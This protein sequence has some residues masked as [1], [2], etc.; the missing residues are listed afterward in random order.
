MKNVS[1]EYRT[2]RHMLERCTVVTHKYYAY[3]GGRGITVCLNWQVSFAY[4]LRDM[5]KRPS[6]LHTLDRIDNSKGYEPDNCRW[7]TRKVQQNNMRGNTVLTLNGE[8]L[9][10]SQW[11]ERLGVKP[12]SISTRLYTGW[13][14]ENTLTVPFRFRS[15]NGTRQLRK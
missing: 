9:T 8:S 4:F 3:Y 12:N 14:V 6:P 2:W 5:G 10:I 7:V 15:T 13:S 1:P 11:G